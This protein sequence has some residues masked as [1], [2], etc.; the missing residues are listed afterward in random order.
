MTQQYSQ[1]PGGQPPQAPFDLWRTAPGGSRFPFLWVILIVALGG[2]FTSGF[3]LRPSGEAQKPAQAKPDDPLERF[4]AALPPPL[5]DPRTERLEEAVRNS[6]NFF[7]VPGR[8]N[9]PAPGAPRPP[10]APTLDPA[11]VKRAAD[12]ERRRRELEAK[13]AQR[14][15]LEVAVKAKE[16]QT[17]WQAE[18]DRWDTLYAKL[19]DGD[20]GR[21]IAG[22]V[23]YV[24]QF[25]SALQAERPSRN[26][27]NESRIGLERIVGP[28][29][30]AAQ[31]PDDLLQPGPETI[32][33][34]ESQASRATQ[35]A[36]IWQEGV[37]EMNALAILARRRGLSGKTT[38]RQA[39]EDLESEMAED[40]LKEKNA[41]LAEA[42]KKAVATDAAIAAAK[43]TGA[44]EIRKTQAEDAQ[45]KKLDEVERGR[46]RQFARGDEVR[47]YLGALMEQG[48][49]QPEPW[50]S[51]ATPKKVG[52]EGPVSLAALRTSG[53]LAPG[54]AGQARLASFMVHPSMDRTRWGMFPE[55][56]LWKPDQQRFI[57]RAQQLLIEYGEAMV[58]EK[59]LAP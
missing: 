39:I 55:K 19:L 31:D 37:Q 47:R 2:L 10:I 54:I 56:E 43:V 14:S 53:C 25:R 15:I 6:S 35:A 17:R 12:A 21:P 24:R 38:L 20:D 32:R 18:L 57:I 59:L 29:E 27:F 58:D 1:G 33:A 4:A 50:G 49:T 42:E 45:K 36:K 13:A 52:D 11:T 22:G 5:T 30:L 51:I 16:A 8:E 7:T 44:A 34:I 9:S 41:R 26:E 46:K 40:R 3:W 28:I 23:E 48:F